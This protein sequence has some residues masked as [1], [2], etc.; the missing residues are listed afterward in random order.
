MKK[1]FILMMVLGVVFV[2]SCGYKRTQT[3]NGKI[4]LTVWET[5]DNQEHTKFLSIAKEWEKQYFNETGKKVYL[6]IQRVPFDDMITNLK[7]AAMAYATPD[8]A[9]VDSLKVVELA[10]GKTLYALDK[11][12]TRTIKEIGKN[13]IPAAFQS[14]VIRVKRDGKFQTHLFGYPEQATC[15]A[16]FWNRDFFKKYAGELRKAGLD[17]NRAPRTMDEFIK[18]G[19]ILTHRDKKEYAFAMNNSLWWTFPFFNL[20]DAKFFEYTS[21]GKVKCIIDNKNAIAALQFKADLYNKY[22]IEAGAWRSG[23]IG[24][25]QGFMNNKYAMIFMGPWR[26]K[27]FKDAKLNFG[28]SLIPAGPYGHSATNIGGNSLVIFKTCKYPKTAYNF[29]RFMTSEKVQKDWS[30]SLGEI[31]VNLRAQKDIDLSKRPYI[32][33]F[34]E[35]LKY[36]KPI[37][38]IPRYGIMESEIMNPNMELVL[39]GKISAAAALKRAKKLINEEILSLVNE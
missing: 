13:F 25:E 34:I 38:R 23:A 18:Y 14:N 16:L 33:I 30:E 11:L 4:V 24:P 8:I 36:A 1:M 10:Y 22:K 28:V 20:F 31:P 29:I 5:Y 27:T 9:R 17:P 7:M 35:Q 39:S 6:N 2:S 26:I 37:P 15:V 21:D 19:E 12:D 32:K 3:K